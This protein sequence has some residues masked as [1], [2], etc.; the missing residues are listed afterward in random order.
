MPTRAVPD[1]L[2]ERRPQLQGRV[3]HY[4]QNMKSYSD[5]RRAVRHP[6]FRPVQAVRV[7]KPTHHNKLRSRYTE[8]QPIQ[9]QLG[10]ATYQ[11]ADGR[12]WNAAKL[13]TTIQLPPEQVPD[14]G[15]DDDDDEDDMYLPPATPVVPAPTDV[16]G[17]TSAS[18]KQ[19][20]FSLP[21]GSCDPAASG[22]L[23]R[24]GSPAAPMEG[25]PRHAALGSPKE[26]DLFAVAEVPVPVAAAESPVPGAVPGSV[27]GPVLGPVPGPAPVPEGNPG[28]A[29]PDTTGVSAPELC[30]AHAAD[31]GQF[32]EPD[33]L[34]RPVPEAEIRPLP[35]PGPSSVPVLGP[36]PGPVGVAVSDAVPG[37]PSESEQP[38][39]GQTDVP[40][41]AVSPDPRAELRGLP[42]PRTSS[43]LGSSGT[44]TPSMPPLED[45]VEEI[46]TEFHTP[47]TISEPP[48]APQPP[49]QGRP[50]R[51]RKA[52]IKFKDC[53][54]GLGW[55]S[56]RV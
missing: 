23:V 50:Q 45:S 18:P 14:H 17:T 42:L 54:G 38:V 48:T 34:V 30:P 55:Q 29:V 39:L 19:V 26:P 27:P 9:A 43:P 12:R 11:L 35:E 15:W 28:S 41:L 46:A 5:H 33:R 47:L 20:E 32:V 21:D 44:S 2:L 16:R 40:D 6:Q 25:A 49:R 51:N 4:Q 31:A 56:R 8:P 1:D 22:L 52:P 13:S 53:Y 37:P 10:P 24:P 7:F 3:E 36:L